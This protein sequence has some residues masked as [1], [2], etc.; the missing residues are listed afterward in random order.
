M[1]RTRCECGRPAVVL[2][3]VKRK[4]SRKTRARQPV[5]LAGHALCPAC[6]RRM[7]DAWHG[8]G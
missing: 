8:K 4:S 3:K 5:S 6:W 7:M 2:P 1:S